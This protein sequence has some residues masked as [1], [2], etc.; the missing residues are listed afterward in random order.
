MSVTNYNNNTCKYR[1]P[2]LDDV[3]YLIS[4]NQIGKISI[5]NGDAY[6]DSIS[7]NPLKF[8]A[9]GVTLS[10]NDA[11][12]ERYKFEHSVSFS[13]L[14]YKSYEDLQGLY[15]V[16]V[17]D[18][19]GTIWL[20]NPQFP[21]KVTYTYTLDSSQS[22]TDFTLSTI[23]NYPT[24]RV[25]N[26]DLK[27]IKECDG[28]V[29][30]GV[31]SLMLNESKYSA[32]EGSKVAY[33][34]DGFKTVGFLKDS[35]T[36]TENFDGEN[37]THSISFKI[38]LDSYKDSWHYNLLEF[39]ENTYAAIVKTNG[40]KV[41]MCGFGY[42][43]QPS[44]TVNGTSTESNYIQV[45]MS[46]MH[47]DG[48]FLS[49]SD[50]EFFDEMNNRWEYSSQY[51][52][53]CIGRN[54]ARY[55]LMYEVDML[56]NKTGRYKCLEGFEEYYEG[57]GLNIVGTFTDNATFNT[58]ACDGSSCDLQTSMPSTIIFN[59]ASCKKYSLL[60]D[61]TWSVESDNPNITV[62]PTNGVGGIPY[63]I[64]ICSKVNPDA[65][66][67]LTFTY[68]KGLKKAYGV[69]VQKG[70]DCF[71]AGEVFDISANGQYVTIPII[72]C[73]NGAKDP[74]GR[75]VE[76]Q[77][78]TNL[79]KVFVP[80]NSTGKDR[81]FTIEVDFCDG[82]KGYITI[83]QSNGFEKWVT[84]G[85]EC[86]G[87]GQR[88]DLQRKYTGTTADFINTPTQT[89]RYTNCFDDVICGMETRWVLTDDTY[90]DMGKKWKVE[91][92]QVKTINGNWEDTGYYRLGEE[93]ADPSGE[94]ALPNEEW[95]VVSGYICDGGNKYKK[96]Q[97]IYGGIGQAVYRKGELIEEKSKDCGWEDWIDD[98]EY[99][100][101]RHVGTTCDGYDKYEQLRLYVSHNMVD[102]VETNVYKLGDI[103]EENS[104]ECGW[105]DGYYYRWNLLNETVCIGYDKYYLYQRQ[106]C[107]VGK[108]I[109]EN[110]IPTQKSYNGNG[111]VSPRLIEHNSEDCG[112]VKPLEPIYGYMLDDYICEECDIETSYSERWLDSGDYICDGFDK[113]SV[114]V[115]E[116]SLDGGN[117][118]FRLLPEESRKGT[119][120]ETNSEDCGW[121]AMYRWTVIPGEYI[122]DEFRKYRVEVYQISAD[123]GASWKD[124]EPRQT[125]K[126]ELIEIDS[127]DCGY[128]YPEPTFGGKFRATYTDGN[129][130]EKN[131]DGNSSLTSGDT[132][133]SGYTYKNMKTA[134]IGSC[135]KEIYYYAFSACT[136][137]TEVTL[138]KKVTNIWPDTFTNCINL[139]NINLPNELTNI[140]R[141]AFSNCT[142]LTE[143]TIP[144]SVTIIGYDAFYGCSGLTSITVLPITPPSVG[145][146][147]KLFDNTNNCPI[148]I[149]DESVELYKNPDFYLDYGWKKYADRIKPLSEKP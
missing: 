5:D 13:V 18:V 37:V 49:E 115:K 99:Q 136:N 51:G 63:V 11:L 121:Q 67:I 128:I 35:C 106:R 122:C 75:I 143:V 86:N 21:S 110:V 78:S 94:C 105:F 113:Y 43:L 17:K 103:Y 92:E 125:R 93:V 132:R 82:S 129:V 127:E 130:Y 8:K 30:N 88:C 102:W 145:Q 4:E 52:F 72:C 73:V 96:E 65:S 32:R 50:V 117:T 71:T 60:S 25:R 79:I 112:Y 111:D 85:T 144:A 134:E 147:T 16:L 124:V 42:G 141:D 137:L 104:E 97:W 55:T 14:G 34:N 69:K 70:N 126:G 22:H 135:V 68:C 133:P 146:I 81:S 139:K 61:D 27:N 90:C 7:G 9:Y 29:I 56:G 107:M 64:E 95:L 100:E 109:W 87:M 31:D 44:F 46:D 118:Y 1:I 66:G 2:K 101:W 84:I 138:S 59:S 38:D 62:S 58:I 54:L 120:I 53:D 57:M 76:I 6:I 91:K 26:L 3:V 41:L 119:L 116:I 123:D 108:N 20:M 83:N 140:G 28:Y 10:D 40:G 48:T 23:S 24:L 36:F 142:S 45:D 148:Y 74:S 98:Y 33:T 47:N 19:E 15:Y 149:P 131:C 77:V 80:Q 89:T 12:D 114:E 39:T